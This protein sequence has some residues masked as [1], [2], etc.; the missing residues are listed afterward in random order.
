MGRSEDRCTTWAWDQATVST[1]KGCERTEKAI[2]HVDLGRAIVLEPQ[3]RSLK[4]KPKTAS[5][6]ARPDGYWVPNA[7]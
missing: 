4:N 1:E 3:A 2:E 7:D 6:G 5:R